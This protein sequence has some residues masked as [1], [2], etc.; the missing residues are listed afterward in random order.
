MHSNITQL[1]QVNLPFSGSRNWFCKR[2]NNIHSNH[3]VMPDWLKFGQ[4]LP[5]ISIQLMSII[6]SPTKKRDTE[7]TKEQCGVSRVLAVKS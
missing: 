7:I 3:Y 6:S 5:N 1:D 2:Y 4:Y